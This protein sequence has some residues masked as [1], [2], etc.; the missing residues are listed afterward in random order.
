MISSVFGSSFFLALIA[1]QACLPPAWPCGARATPLVQPPSEEE[2]EVFNTDTRVPKHSD[3]STTS[4]CSQVPVGKTAR[5]G[6]TP[7]RRG[8][9][10]GMALAACGTPLTR[11]W[12]NVVNTST[13]SNNATRASVLHPCYKM[14]SCA[15]V[16][17]CCLGRV[18]GNPRPGDVHDAP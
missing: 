9:A 1:L 5:I 11:P 4:N 18:A 10:T 2:G 16:E 3:K 15:L 17:R 6:H 7:D 13:V 8:N 14:N 12:C